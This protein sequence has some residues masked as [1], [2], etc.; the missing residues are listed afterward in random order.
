MNS[1]DF[2]NK[3]STKTQSLVEVLEIEFQ[4]N[5]KDRHRNE[6]VNNLITES[7]DTLDLKTLE[8]R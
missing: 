8:T 2:K 1:W 5:M 7:E 6:V 4:L 3:V